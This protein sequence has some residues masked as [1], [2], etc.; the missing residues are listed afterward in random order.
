M[1]NSDLQ[2]RVDEWH[3]AYREFFN[4]LGAI[5]FGLRQQPGACGEWNVRQVV[6]HLSGWHAIALAE[7][8][9]FERGDAP[10]TTFDDDAVNAENVAARAH[11]DWTQTLAELRVRLATLAD[12]LDGLIK[13]GGS[14]DPRF[15]Q[16]LQ[17]LGDDARDHMTQ[18]ATWVA[19]MD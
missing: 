8:E 9:L 15:A 10:H 6:A 13:R 2:H 7:F 18:I 17:A 5:P 19:A 11:L 1:P 3:T 14:D 12:Y 4:G 16:W